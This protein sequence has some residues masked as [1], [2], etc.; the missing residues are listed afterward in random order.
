VN[1]LKELAEENQKFDYVI[2]DLSEYLIDTEKGKYMKKLE[3]F[4]CSLGKTSFNVSKGTG[5]EQYI[6]VYI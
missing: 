4:A 2:N 1:V 5:Y 3:T 6:F